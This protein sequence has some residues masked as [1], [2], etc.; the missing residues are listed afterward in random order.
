MMICEDQLHSWL[1]IRIIYLEIFKEI[2]KT[3]LAWLVGVI[4]CDREVIVQ[5]ERWE[6]RVL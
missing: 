1:E 2:K 5:A 3:A 6:F 4:F